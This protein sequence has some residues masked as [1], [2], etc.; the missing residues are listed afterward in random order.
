[1][2]V[3]AYANA[4]GTVTPGTFVPDIAPGAPKSTPL[5]EDQSGVAGSATSFKDTVK[6]LLDNVNNQMVEAQQNSTNYALGKT[7]NLEA[8]VQSVEEASIAM[9]MTMEIRNK[10]LSAY[11]EISQMQF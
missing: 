4:V 7:N 1:M 8:T 3:N 11:T 2:D 6:S 10:L 9:S 5:P